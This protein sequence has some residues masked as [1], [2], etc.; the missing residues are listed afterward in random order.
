MTADRSGHAKSVPHA[1]GHV[2]EV[3]PQTRPPAAPPLL[4]NLP[5]HSTSQ[6]L[7]SA[8][9]HEIE[10]PGSGDVRPPGQRGAPRQAENLAAESDGILAV[11]ARAQK[12]SAPPQ[13]QVGGA[14]RIS[15]RRVPAPS[16]ELAGS[17]PAGE[18]AGRRSPGP[19]P[20]DWARASRLAQGLPPVVTDPLVL[21]NVQTIMRA[22]LQDQPAPIVQLKTRSQRA[23]KNPKAQPQDDLPRRDVAL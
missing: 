7:L 5:S 2:P 19:T 22:G 8:P 16:V 4:L 9:A 3:K 17:S 14:I 10:R 23:A 13:P 1:G 18:S 6:R 12:S 20:E 21:R 11:Q 15:R